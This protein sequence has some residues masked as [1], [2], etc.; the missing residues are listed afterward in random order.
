MKIKTVSNIF[1]DDKKHM[2]VFQVISNYA[3]LV[4]MKT[5]LNIFVDNKRR[6]W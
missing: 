5:L 1:V 3:E 6:Y 2:H 4:K